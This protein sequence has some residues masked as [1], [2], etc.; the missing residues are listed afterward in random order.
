M[1]I[2]VLV[3]IFGQNLPAFALLLVGLA[4]EKHYVGRVTV[5]TNTIAVSLHIATL[6]ETPT[7]MAVYGNF[8]LL[9]G[10]YGL[11]AYLINK[12][13][14]ILFNFPAYSLYSSVPVALVIL[15]PPGAWLPALVL[16]SIVSL[17]VGYVLEEEFGVNVSHWGPRTADVER[18]IRTAT[19]E[20]VDAHGVHQSVDLSYGE[21]DW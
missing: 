11:T 20:Y 14:S 5:F 18:F 15:T 13:T 2:D 1:L 7:L 6:P 3:S 16:A 17:V 19:L 9:L 4:V 10:L 12:K 8:G 21:L